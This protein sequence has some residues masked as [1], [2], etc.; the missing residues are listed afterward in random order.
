M[1]A[2]TPMFNLMTQEG[3]PVFF[4][5]DFRM[6]L[7]KHIDVFRKEKGIQLITVD[8]NVALRYRGDF[9][10]LMCYYKIPLK[11]HWIIMRINNLHS[12]FE[13]TE[14]LR[15]LLIPNFESIEQLKATFTTINLA[16]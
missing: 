12:T 16:I 11:Y 4:R 7:E 3:P 2:D 8:P 10:G 1:P 14:E 9:D 5:D 15:G 6:E 13:Y